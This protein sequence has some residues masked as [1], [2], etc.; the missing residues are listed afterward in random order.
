MFLSTV[1][2]DFCQVLFLIHWDDY[3]LFSNKFSSLFVLTHLLICFLTLLV[4]SLYWR[5]H[6]HLDFLLIASQG[7]EIML[8]IILYPD[9]PLS[10]ASIQDFYRC[11]H[12]VGIPRQ[13]FTGII[14]S[15]GSLAWIFFLNRYMFWFWF[16]ESY[17]RPLV[18]REVIIDSGDF[19]KLCI[20]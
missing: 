13:V 6:S 12:E 16:N 7:A 14:D 17:W 15:L 3:G 9:N 18:W 5:L 19:L 20:L 8:C 4:T 10:V 2:V 11:S 1:G